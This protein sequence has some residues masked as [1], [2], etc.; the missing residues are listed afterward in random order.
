M[1]RFNEPW[2]KGLMPDHC[3]MEYNQ[4]HVYLDYFPVAVKP[5]DFPSLVLDNIRTRIN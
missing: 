2:T 5:A 4:V 3:N 1:P